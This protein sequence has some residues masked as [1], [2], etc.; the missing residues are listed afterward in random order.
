MSVCLH[1]CTAMP[2]WIWTLLSCHKNSA[3]PCVA[4]RPWD[5]SIM[6]KT[7]GSGPL[8]LLLKE[9]SKRV[10]VP[11]TIKQGA[12]VTDSLWPLS[13]KLI[14]AVFCCCAQ[15]GRGYNEKEMHRGHANERCSHIPPD[16]C[17][18]KACRRGFNVHVCVWKSPVTVVLVR[19]PCRRA[20]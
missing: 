8:G 13:V 15:T 12:A 14:L 19:S 3:S 7:R 17:T 1:A 16:I 18:E 20:G 10:K 2:D 9:C 6:G 5:N 11:G 4:L